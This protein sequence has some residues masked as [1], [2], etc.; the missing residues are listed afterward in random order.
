VQED[1]HTL[2]YGFK[3]AGDETDAAVMSPVKELEEELGRIIKVSSDYQSQFRLS[4]STEH[5]VEL[6][7]LFHFFIIYVTTFVAN[8]TRCCYRIVYSVF[9]FSVKYFLDILHVEME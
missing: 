3:M 4:R 5:C 8:T 9:L 7:D 2:T 6:W 1:F